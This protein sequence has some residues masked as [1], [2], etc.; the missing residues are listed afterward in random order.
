VPS[1]KSKEDKPL[2]DHYIVIHY[3]TRRRRALNVKKLAV[4][5]ADC[6]SLNLEAPN[7]FA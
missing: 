6:V 1:A 5:L 2:S 7:R 3:T 4:E